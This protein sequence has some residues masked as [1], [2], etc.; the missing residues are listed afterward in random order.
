MLLF[1][2]INIYNIFFYEFNILLKHENANNHDTW[3]VYFV[4]NDVIYSQRAAGREI[5]YLKIFL[6]ENIVL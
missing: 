3:Q 5:T 6:K 4:F 2:K 1:A